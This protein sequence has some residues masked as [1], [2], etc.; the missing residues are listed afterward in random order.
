MGRE[1]LE[2]DGDDDRQRRA[3]V[4][5]RIKHTM[6]TVPIWYEAG[7]QSNEGFAITALAKGPM[8]VYHS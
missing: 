2:D 6:S 5:D 4:R 3:H 7:E 8:A 1:Q